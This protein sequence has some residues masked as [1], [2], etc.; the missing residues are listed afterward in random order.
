LPNGVI[1]LAVELEWTLERNSARFGRCAGVD[2]LTG[3]DSG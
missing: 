2:V 3:E 1:E